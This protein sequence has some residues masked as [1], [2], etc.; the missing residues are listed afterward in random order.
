MPLGERITILNC[1]SSEARVFRFTQFPNSS[2]LRILL[3][4]AKKKLFFSQFDFDHF[5]MPKEKR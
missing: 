1:Q 4:I 2:V 3:N 5:I